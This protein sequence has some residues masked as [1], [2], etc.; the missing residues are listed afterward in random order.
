MNLDTVFRILARAFFV[1][2]STATGI[3]FLNLALNLLG[4]KLLWINY[5]PG[6]LLELSAILLVFV[7]VIF[8]RQIRDELRNSNRS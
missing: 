2:A 5:A 3:A 1:V 6:R 7:I 8:L 4:Y